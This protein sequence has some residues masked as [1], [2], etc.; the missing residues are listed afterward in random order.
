MSGT[1]PESAARWEEAGLWFD[2]CDEDLDTAEACLQRRPPLLRSAAYHCQQAAEKLLKGLLIAAARS[3]RKIHDLDELVEQVS[4][5]HADLAE[6]LGDLRPL[7][8]WGWA[9]RY[10]E[11]ADEE[12]NSPTVQ[13]IEAAL[14]RLRGLRGTISRFAPGGGA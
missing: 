4:H 14:D 8:P 7:T 9:F 10:P 12:G 11:L 5:V 1:D 2:I 3:F 6:D 13:E